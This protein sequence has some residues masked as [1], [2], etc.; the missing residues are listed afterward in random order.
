MNLEPADPRPYLELL[1]YIYG[2]SNDMKAAQST[3]DAGIANGVDPVTLNFAL[4]DAA[5]T[6]KQP[7]IAEAAMKKAVHYAPTF[8]NNLRL[9]DFYLGS[10]NPDRAVDVLRTAITMQP[11]SADAYARLAGAEEAAYLYADADRDYAHA[12]QL[13]PNDQG[14]KTRYTEFHKR[15][16]DEAAG[17]KKSNN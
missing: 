6:A 7:A 3:V 11:D 5:Q 14:L 4:A 1:S 9:A 13:A 17:L 2:P 12:A 16:T 8:Q 15:I 10:G